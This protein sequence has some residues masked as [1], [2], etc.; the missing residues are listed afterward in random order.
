MQWDPIEFKIFVVVK[1]TKLK[2]V[3]TVSEK[4]KWK[5][6]WKYK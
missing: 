3:K 4:W 6:K 5:W 1:I 2:Q